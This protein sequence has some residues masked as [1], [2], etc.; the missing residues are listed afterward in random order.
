MLDVL[1]KLGSVSSAVIG[2]IGLALTVFALWRARKASGAADSAPP[3]ENAQKESDETSP[4]LIV[5][6]RSKWVPS[7]DN[8]PERETRNDSY[9]DSSVQIGQGFKPSTPRWLLVA[10][11]GVILIATAVVLNMQP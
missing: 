8:L 2:L 7:S 9:G 6:P 5:P 1:D 3:I 4:R 11:L 10:S